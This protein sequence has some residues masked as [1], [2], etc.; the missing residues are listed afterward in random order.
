M[1]VGN[2]YVENQIQA[3]GKEYENIV[4]QMKFEM[5]PTGSLAVTARNSRNSRVML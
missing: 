4:A 2:M 5:T 3:E 1:Y